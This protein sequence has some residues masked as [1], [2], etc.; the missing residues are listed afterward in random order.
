MTADELIAKIREARVEQIRLSLA[1]QLMTWGIAKDWDAANRM[2]K[3]L[4]DQEV[5][6]IWEAMHDDKILLAQLPSTCLG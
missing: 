6:R 4:T 1:G 3:N 5:M 2:L